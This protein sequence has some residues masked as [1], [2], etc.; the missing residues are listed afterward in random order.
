MKKVTFQLVLT[1]QDDACDAKDLQKEITTVLE[2]E[3]PF[4]SFDE[5]AELTFLKEEIV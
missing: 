2:D 4:I 3:Y 1:L 5:T